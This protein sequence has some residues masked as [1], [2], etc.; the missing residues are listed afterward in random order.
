MFS[1]FQAIVN[2][3]RT[4]KPATTPALLRSRLS[5]EVASWSRSEGVGCETTIVES[6]GYDTL[7]VE[8]LFSM[9]KASEVDKMSRA[10]VETPVQKSV[11][12]LAGPADSYCTNPN[13]TACGFA[14]SS[15]MSVSE[16]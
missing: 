9:L 5:D 2:K 14:L 6:V 12:F 4:N 10:R 13:P 3:V 16:E 15:L 1:R 11:A 8:E 7:T